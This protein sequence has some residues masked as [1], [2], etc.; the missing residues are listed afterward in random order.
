MRYVRLLLVALTCLVSASIGFAQDSPVLFERLD[1][2]QGLSNDAVRCLLQDRTGFLWVGTENGLNRYDGTRFTVYR[3]QADNLNSISGNAIAT[4]FEDRDG[5]IW[6]GTYKAGVN[7]YDP[8]RDTFERIPLLR[9][10]ALDGLPAT[11]YCVAQDAAGIL[12]FG[13][14]H[15]LVSF[16]RRTGRFQRFPKR[17]A[18]IKCLS[19]DRRGKLWVGH[20]RALELFD[21]ATGTFETIRA[22]NLYMTDIPGYR[23]MTLHP[24][25][26]VFLATLDGIEMFDTGSKR[27]LGKLGAAAGDA[28]G[29]LANEKVSFL[30]FTDP[31]TLWAS[32]IKNGLF[33]IELKTGSVTRYG[34]GATQQGGLTGNSPRTLFLDRTGILWVGDSSYG[35][36]KFSKFSHRFRLYQHNPYDPKSLSDNYI[37]GICRDRTGTVWVGTQYGGLNRIDPNG[38][39]TRYRHDEKRPGSIPNDSVWTV[40]EDRQGELWLGTA[41]GF[42]RFNPATGT[43]TALNLPTAGGLVGAVTEDKEGNLWFFVGDRLFQLDQSRKPVRMVEGTRF[44]RENSLPLAVQEVFMDR[45]GELWVGFEEGVAR[46]NP[47]TD[48]IVRYDAER[49]REGT[50][51]GPFYG[52]C[53][54]E[55]REGNLWIA[56]KGAGIHR[57]DRE[58]DQFIHVTEKNNLPNNNVYGLFEDEAGNFWMSTDNGVARYNPKDKLVRTFSPADGLQGL[59]FNRRAFF[60]APDGELFFGGTSGLNRFYPKDIRENL[61][62]PSIVVTGV[63]TPNG[64]VEFETGIES[65]ITLGHDDNTLT[66]TF[67]S[68]DFNAPQK[69]RY[70]YRLEGVDPKYVPSHKPEVT[71]PKLA[72]GTYRFQVWGTNNDGIWSKG[73]VTFRLRI[74]PP[75]WR[76]WWAYTGYGVL[77]SLFF[78]GAFRLQA[79]R[80]R[81]RARLR[82][83]ALRAEVAEKEQQ[84]AIEQVRAKEIETA[85]LERENLRR[86]LAESVLQAKNDELAEANERLK[87]IDNI[88]QGFTAMLVHDLKSP[89]TSV[90]SVLELL[91]SGNT[92][93]QPLD[94]TELVRGSQ[95]NLEQVV[96][97]VDEVLEVFRSENRD[98]QIVRTLLNPKDILNRC[99]QNAQATALTKRIS[100]SGRL[101]ANL[102]LIEGDFGKLER[103]FLNLLSN[104]LKF[105]PPGGVITVEASAV[106]GKGVETGLRLVMVTITDTGPGI[107]AEDLPYIFDPYRQSTEGRAKVGVG[108][109][110]AI[111]KRVAAAHGGSVSVRSQVGVGSSFTVLLP[112]L[113]EP[114]PDPV[115]AGNPACI[116]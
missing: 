104:A 108:L 57:H 18:G 42:G 110:L 15:D 30:L 49:F 55:D 77:F 22:D 69:N 83:A 5:F 92:D 109:G 44:R 65:T 75:W 72:P 4:L 45:F 3:N 112:A 29:L 114:L 102:P 52:T 1:H 81:I 33:R 46:Y 12:W 11:V 71:Y 41:D 84:V 67:A 54:M 27:P 17:D 13:G 107:P 14:H 98:I 80:L 38:T 56:S 6:I 35:L 26:R 40:F 48:T 99:I 37:R 9:D 36:S 39:V 94:V 91:D 68:L 97:L 21:P 7:R 103:V 89:L 100:L 32:T 25:G 51:S 101:A 64:P 66:V 31:E 16:D 19:F 62:N 86:A 106:E 8:I 59:E 34:A 2:E 96:H 111:V 53:F 24:D 50:V 73:N 28:P 10:N 20:D 115:R 113:A 79:T 93:L 63:S 70:L 105:T 116:S 60:K 90:K 47:R 88:K 23:A 87:E 76:T 85:A 74:L 58:R 43:F 78:F 95:E 61:A 82:E